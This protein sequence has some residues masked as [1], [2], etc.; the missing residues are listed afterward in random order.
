MTEFVAWLLRQTPTTTKDY[1]PLQ[2]NSGARGKA[3]GQ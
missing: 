2:V 1:T 3:A